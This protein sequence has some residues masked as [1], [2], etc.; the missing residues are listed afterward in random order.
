MITAITWSPHDPRLLAS[1]STDQVIKVWDIETEMPVAEVRGVGFAPS[2]IRWCAGAPSPLGPQG[3]L[4]EECY[5][6]LATLSR[7]CKGHANQ[8]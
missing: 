2:L 3:W 6:K 7:P 4:I 5:C 8:R 1:C